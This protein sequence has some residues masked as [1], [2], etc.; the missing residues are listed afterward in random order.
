[1]RDSSKYLLLVTGDTIRRNT[2]K[3]LTFSLQFR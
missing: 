3:A 1:M 2:L